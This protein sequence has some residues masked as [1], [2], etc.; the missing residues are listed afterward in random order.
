[1]QPTTYV[2]LE[3]AEQGVLC[4]RC[5]GCL[6]VCA[7]TCFTETSGALFDGAVNSITLC[8]LCLAEG[9]G[10]A[11]GFKAESQLRHWRAV[12]DAS[13]RVKAASK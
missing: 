5:K 4:D 12:R 6:E 9:I 8:S 11:T 1:M 2:K 13:K 10:K 7:I 3:L